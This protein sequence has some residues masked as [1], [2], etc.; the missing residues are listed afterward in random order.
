MKFLKKIQIFT[1]FV[2]FADLFACEKIEPLEEVQAEEYNKNES[3]ETFD[4]KSSEGSDNGRKPGSGSGGGITDPGNDD[5][6]DKEDPGG[7]DD[8]DSNT[9]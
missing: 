1:M 5:D 9:Q 8:G 6:Y 3:G 4:T 2:L 7:G